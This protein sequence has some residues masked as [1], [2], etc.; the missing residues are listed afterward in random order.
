[1]LDYSTTPFFP[2]SPDGSAPS[3]RPG[4]QA[5]RTAHSHHLVLTAMADQ[6]A[7]LML[8]GA[9]LTLTFCLADVTRAPH[10]YP[11]MV[12]GVTALGVALCALKA[13]TP[14]I[15]MLTRDDSQPEVNLLFC[16]HFCVMGENEYV[17]KLR[18]E[19]DNEE[20]AFDMLAR[21]LYQLGLVLHQK[22]LRA[23]AMAITVAMFGLVA[24]AVTAV[25]TLCLKLQ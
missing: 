24:T 25:V 22:K 8:V 5:L 3:L 17:A 14:R 20:A 10:A 18:E 15:L 16:G 23:V 7:S 2:M 13:L 9:L 6:K 21:D 1:L 12:L 11:F 4:L 19:L